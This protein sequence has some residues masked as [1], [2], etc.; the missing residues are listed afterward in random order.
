MKENL[1]RRLRVLF[2]KQEVDMTAP[3]KLLLL[4]LFYLIAKLQEITTSSFIIQYIY[5]LYLSS[6]TMIFFPQTKGLFTHT[7]SD[8]KTVLPLETESLWRLKI[9]SACLVEGKQQAKSR[10][11]QQ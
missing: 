4:L 11:K 1:D 6:N 9:V 7:G 2:L 3:E 8:C 10:L 5:F